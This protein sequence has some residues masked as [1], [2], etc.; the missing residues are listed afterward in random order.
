MTG[1]VNGQDRSLYEHEKGPRFA[2]GGEYEIL[3]K[4]ITGLTPPPKKKMVKGAAVALSNR[5]P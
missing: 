4:K 1:A 2:G 5:F 3:K